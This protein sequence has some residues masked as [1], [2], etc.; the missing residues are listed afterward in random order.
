MRV[1]WLSCNYCVINSRLW[2]RSLVVCL[3]STLHD[4]GA[5]KNKKKHL[6][7]LLLCRDFFYQASNCSAKNQSNQSFMEGKECSSF[8]A[9]TMSKEHGSW[10]LLKKV[11]FKNV[12]FQ[13]VET[14]KKLAPTA[15]SA[16]PTVSCPNFCLRN[17]RHQVHSLVGMLRLAI[18]KRRVSTTKNT[19]SF[20][21][22]DTLRVTIC[23]DRTWAEKIKIS[24]FF[25]PKR[26]EI[27]LAVRFS[28]NLIFVLFFTP[29]TSLQVAWLSQ[30]PT[31]ISGGLLILE[32][33]F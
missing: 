15:K 7:T 5:R 11:K 1:S 9:T 26:V 19:K 21:D 24:P 14:V 30:L 23:H 4:T 16:K 33:S 13:L 28:K 31:M 17:I 18:L 20:L 22:I 10:I 32:A 6:N 2:R 29:L 27:P 25:W 3:Q 12:P 8:V